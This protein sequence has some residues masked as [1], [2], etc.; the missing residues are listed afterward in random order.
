M[1]KVKGQTIESRY[2]EVLKG[3]KNIL[4]SNDDI[5][6]I[7]NLKSALS[8][9]KI[10]NDIY[11]VKALN[12]NFSVFSTESGSLKWTGT[13][14]NIKMARKLIDC[15]KENRKKIPSLNKEQKKTEEEKTIS[16]TVSKS[17]SGFNIKFSVE[18]INIKMEIQW[19]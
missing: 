6:N 12:E 4:D 9:E 14:P 11:L 17:V 10:S 18:N 19:K 5:Y 16:H 3:I 13:T 7:T 15:V 8:S 1:K 2:L